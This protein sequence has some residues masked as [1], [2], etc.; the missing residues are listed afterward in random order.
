MGKLNDKMEHHKEK[1][2]SSHEVLAEMKLRK[3]E[4]S[5]SIYE[6]YITYAHL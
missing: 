6:Y 2:M 4:M 3:T 5:V 1:L